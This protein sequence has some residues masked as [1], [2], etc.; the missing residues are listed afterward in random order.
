[1]TG[2]WVPLYLA[3]PAQLGP[4]VYWLGVQ[5]G[6]ANGV[7]RFGWNSKAGSRRFNVDAFG[8]GASDPFGT[9]LADDQQLSIFAAGSY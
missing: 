1:M 9:G 4:G 3:P 5:S 8:D 7:A 2:R 6:G